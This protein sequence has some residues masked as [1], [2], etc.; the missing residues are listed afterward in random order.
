M[1]LLLPLT[2]AASSAPV[3]I[4]L[5]TSQGCSSCPP[6]EALMRDLDQSQAAPGFEIIPLAFHVDYW[7]RLGW[8][9]PWAQA[10][11]TRRQYAYSRARGAAQVYTP[12]ALV[13]GGADLVG[14]D[15]AGLLKARRPTLW[16]QQAWRRSLRR[17][18]GWGTASQ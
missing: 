15:K 7:D 5:F 3:I 13:N 14:H 6:A 12:Q 1:S 11:F 8:K 10:G 17:P 16:W 4:E 2:S 9:D 18:C